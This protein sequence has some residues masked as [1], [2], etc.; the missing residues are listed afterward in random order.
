MEGL[1]Q[2][3][4][5]H[6]YAIL[7]GMVLA[8][9][10]GLPVP[11][12]LALLG[13]GG[14]ASRA[15]LHPGQVLATGIGAMLIGDTILF[16]LGRYTGWWLLG[17]LCRFSLNPEACILQ[18]AESFHRRGRIIM[19]F[20]KFLPGVNTMAAPL[21]GSM[22]MPVRQFLPLDLAGASLYV[23]TWFSVGYVFNGLLNQIAS[24]YSS[25][26]SVLGWGAAGL[27]ALWLGNRVR[28]WLKVRKESPVPMVLPQDVLEK[29]DV[30]IFDVR[31][32]GYYDAGTMRIQGSLR[33]EPNALAEHIGML[34]QHREIV[35]YCTCV[36]EATA[37]KVARMLAE[38]GIPSS[39]L[40]GGLSGW[41]KAD[42]PLE[43]VP[44]TD[45]V[46]LPKFA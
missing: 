8:E 16:L 37:V 38:R 36:N 32:H 15:A 2:L 22:N 40:V 34:P 23:G 29:A 7:F 3:I 1:L 28:L 10:L 45:V 6:G 19:V 9:S 21:A 4:E 14:A 24:G 42:L 25:M 41:K 44:A 39:V 33:L 12:A 5:H 46:M 17:M 31:S 27:F 11:A 43:P 13:A 20:A 26:G 30:A 35:L 18:S